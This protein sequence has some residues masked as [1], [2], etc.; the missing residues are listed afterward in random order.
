MTDERVGRR[1]SLEHTMA[2]PLPEN[3]DGPRAAIR[4]RSMSVRTDASKILSDLRADLHEGEEHLAWLLGEVERHLG[5][6]DAKPEPV[7][8]PVVEAAEA[9]S[10]GGGD[11]VA[12]E[13]TEE[14]P[15]TPRRRKTT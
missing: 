10:D 14:V 1:M 9:S 8:A 6:H 7:A 4:R 15:P 2:A 12:E 3:T 5:I 13:P 11:E